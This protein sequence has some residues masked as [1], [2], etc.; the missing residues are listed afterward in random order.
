MRA[1]MLIALLTTILG[2]K[3]QEVVLRYDCRSPDWEKGEAT[4]EI[5]LK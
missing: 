3:S 4:I 1:W 2:C 5:R